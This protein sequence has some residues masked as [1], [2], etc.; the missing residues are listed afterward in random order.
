MCLA[1][2][3]LLAERAL[4]AAEPQTARPAAA[5]RLHAPP[6]AS[7]EALPPGRGPLRLELPAEL[8]GAQAPP[9][10]LPPHDPSQ[11][12]RRLQAIDELFP[13]LPPLPSEIARQA[14]PDGQ[15]LQLAQ[16]E[17]LALATNPV[18]AQ[19]M[20]Q[21]NA[22]RG[23][24]IQAGLPPNPTI[25]YEA[26]TV[27]S[28]GTANYHGAYFNQLVK[29]AGKLSLARQTL[30]FGVRNAELEL[31]KTRVALI[32]T[33][34]SRYYAVLVADEAVK[35]THALATFMDQAFRIQVE[36]LRGGEAAAYEP[37]QLRGLA[38]QARTLHMQ[39]RNR[40]FAAWSQLAASVNAP[41]MPP[42]LLAG[43]VH[44]V[45]PV[46]QFDQLRD[47]MF[48]VHPDLVA[49]RNSY[50]QAR[51]NLRLQQLIPVP[52]VELYLTVQKDFTAPP[53]GA[54]I[55]TQVGFPTALFNRNTGAILQAQAELAK[56]SQ[57]AARVRNE[58]VAELAGA[59]ERLENGRALVDYY[60]D[61]I[62]PDQTRV[63]RGIYEQH[64]QQPDRVTF[65]DVV[66]AQQTLAAS[67]N[68]YLQA[69]GGQW[70]A[71]AELQNLL[72]VE[73]LSELAGPPEPPPAAP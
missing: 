63:Y 51:A 42:T 18:I 9:L 40:F 21:V 16:L 71:V 72:Q 2:A 67:V 19:A 35:S 22:A 3:C 59:F 37:M 6:V 53:Y 46:L 11:P 13:P 34:Q 55:N 29:T 44:A 28:G 62:L 8:P 20:A 32:T 66:L 45:L 69:L 36:Q 23:A 39:A 48:A 24:A 12:A 1:A 61:L 52:D 56:A 14:G 65:D 5:V 54:T 73:D 31:R 15:P 4:P 25:G 58:L 64:Q 7:T 30:W 60:R 50:L 41:E 33:V 10:R 38:N 49:A 57:Q 47:Q 26:D 43:N 27:G 17:S 68:N 70:Q